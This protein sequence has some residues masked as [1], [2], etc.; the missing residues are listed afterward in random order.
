MLE[1]INGQYTTKD[2]KTI[3]NDWEEALKS[4]KRYKN[5]YINNRVGPLVVGIYL[6]MGRLNT[7]YTP[8]YYVHNL[9]RTFPQLTLTMSIKEKMIPTEKH[10]EM[11]MREA[12]SLAKQAYISIDGNL[13]INE[14]IAGYERYF[15]SPNMT[16]YVEYEDLA[17]ICGWTK[18]AKKI[19]YVLNIVY[20]ELKSWPEERYFAEFDGFEKWFKSLEKKVWDGDKLR[21]IVESELMKHKLV[22]IPER[23]ILF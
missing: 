4:L 8:I 17:L 22:K 2:K 3:T 23:K 19:E 9:C 7:Y 20:N 18:E 21:S 14:V 16:S 12:E 11:Y 15:I 6:K 1:G 13:N 5:L 10:N